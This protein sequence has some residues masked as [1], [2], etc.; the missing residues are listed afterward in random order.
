MCK[1]SVIIP[2][3]NVERYLPACLD[4]VLNQTLKDLEIVAIDDA[5]PDNSGKILDEYAAKDS[6]V[7]VLH[8]PENHMQGY[9]RNRGIEMSKGEYLYFLDSDDMITPEAME[10]LYEISKRDDLDAVFFDSQTLYEDEELKK[11]HSNYLAVR[12]GNYPDAV[13][14]GSDL[15]DLFCE[16]DEWLVYVQRE[17]WRR[18]LLTD[19]H[20]LNIEGVEHEDEFF[21]FSAIL[22]AKR[23]RYIRKPYFI[24]R[25][26]ANSVM[27]RPP[28]PKDFHGYFTTYCRMIRFAEEKGLNSVGVDYNIQHMF[29][30]VLNFQQVFDTQADPKDWFHGDDLVLHR[31]FKEIQTREERNRDRSAEL[32]RPLDDYL[33]IYIY[34]AG[35]VA[36][37]AAK[38]I[39]SAGYSI[40]GFFVS[41]LE[42]NP[43]HMY[44]RRVQDFHEISSL[45]E[46][47]VVVAAVGKPMHEEISSI[48]EQKGF[49]YFL[50][51]GGVLTGPFDPNRKE[52]ES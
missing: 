25:Y 50:Y 21:S 4:S 26:R 19:N 33:N 11:R 13:L 40:S 24:R 2:V 5:S 20:I 47:S 8:L 36:N 28:M 14:T 29:D 37:S 52:D 16:Q 3:Y 30:C 43:E 48:L 17:F 35:R 9:G 27:T 31:I 49:P 7:R 38:Q 44:H 22:S 6:R 23:A 46:G 10:E 41:S 42:G 12:S 18:S 34:G 51:A 32:W 15:L 45:P 1:V 39:L